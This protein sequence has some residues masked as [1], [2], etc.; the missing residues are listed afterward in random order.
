MSR[1]LAA[2]RT[3][4]RYW[5]GF[6]FEASHRPA[7]HCVGAALVPALLVLINHGAILPLYSALDEKLIFYQWA[8]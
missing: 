3:Y 4:A 8:F 7:A 5:P 6:R 2:G 1:K